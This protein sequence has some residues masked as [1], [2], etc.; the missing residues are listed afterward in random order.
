MCVCGVCGVRVCVVNYVLGQFTIS[1]VNLQGDC[2][3]R[4]VWKDG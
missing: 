4:R 2:S 3:Q 1:Y